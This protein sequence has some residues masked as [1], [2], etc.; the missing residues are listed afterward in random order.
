MTTNSIIDVSGIKVGQAE[1]HKALTGCTV[2][3]CEKGAVAGVSQRGGAPG[4]RETDLLH[5]GHMIQKVHAVLLSGGSAY[6]LDAAG[7]VM[8]YLE[9]KK[10]GFPAGATVVPIVPSAILYDLDFGDHTVRPG[11]EMGYQA[12]IN[13]ATSRPNEGNFGA[14]TGATVGKI[15]GSDQAMKSG[16][17]TASITTGNG[18]VIAAMIAVNAFGD[19]IENDNIIAGTR[20]LKKG[21]LKLGADEIFADTREVMQSFAGRQILSFASRQNTVIGVIATN[22]ILTKEEANHL[23]DVASNGISYAIRPAFTMFD[24]DTLF[25]LATG[26]IKADVNLIAAYAPDV[27]SQAIRSGVKAAQ[28]AAG[29]PAYSDLLSGKVES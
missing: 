15:L 21:P 12:C 18:I 26:K 19:V 17:G 23:A 11:K 27:V 20:T 25:A 7:G 24:G 3:I 29:L 22:A 6:G 9:E 8:Q 2:I 10:I 4:T 5:T 1:D 14:G 13:A 16:I 28:S